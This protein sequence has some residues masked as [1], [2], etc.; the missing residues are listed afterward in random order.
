MRNWTEIDFSSIQNIL[1]RLEDKNLIKYEIRDPN[2]KN[3]CK[4]YEITDKGRVILKEKIK[5]ILSTREKII[6]PLD[7]GIAN[8]NVLSD[9]QIVQSLDHY[10]S[11]WIIKSITLINPLNYKRRIIYPTIL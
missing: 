10:T 6:S 9:G 3:S 2:S 4:V 7:L 1:N 11:H 8:M 5:N